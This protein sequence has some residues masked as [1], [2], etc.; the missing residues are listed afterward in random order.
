[1]A[2]LFQDHPAPF[3]RTVTF[4]G[5]TW[6]G[7][8]GRFTILASSGAIFIKRLALIC[9]SALIGEGA[10]ISLGSDSNP[11][12][13]IG[14]TN[15]SD[16][17]AGD[18]WGGVITDR[19][20][21]GSVVL[22]VRGADITSGGFDIVVYYSPADSGAQ[23]SFHSP[24]APEIPDSIACATFCDGRVYADGLDLTCTF[25]QESGNEELNG[26]YS[27]FAQTDFSNFNNELDSWAFEPVQFPIQIAWMSPEFDNHGDK[28]L[29]VLLPAATPQEATALRLYVAQHT[30]INSFQQGTIIPVLQLADYPNNELNNPEFD[31]VGPVGNF[32]TLLGLSLV[33]AYT[34]ISNT[35][36]AEAPDGKQW[37]DSGGCLCELV[38]TSV[39]ATVAG[40]R[41]AVDP[42]AP[43]FSIL[44]RDYPLTYFGKY[45]DHP[46]ADAP[47]ISCGP[48]DDSSLWQS[49]ALSIE[50]RDGHGEVVGTITKAFLV[51]STGSES[52]QIWFLSDVDLPYFLKQDQECGATRHRCW[53]GTIQG[54]EQE[55]YVLPLETNELQVPDFGTATIRAS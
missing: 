19:V 48:A 20:L 32:D 49:G 51:T 46:D 1:M 29:M 16:L 24:E 11:S 14:A 41:D 7:A 54:V 50:V 4:D 10:I 35:E 5:S 15:F 30:S 43:L 21:D 2:K 38:D 28:Y 34:V 17:N 53:S 9:R 18:V 45:S 8:V 26:H 13:L 36:P 42:D 3:R 22:T 12:A 25:T 33:S 37:V 44:N 23:P 39:T 27:L 31:T 55:P 6:A 40:V 47:N 52:V